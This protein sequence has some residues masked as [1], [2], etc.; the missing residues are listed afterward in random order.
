MNDTW[1][2][3]LLTPP[4]MS[5]IA[6]IGI[7]GEMGLGKLLARIKLRRDTSLQQL[8]IG[9][10]A[11][12]DFRHKEGDAAEEVV[13]V[14]TAADAME[15][16]CHGGRAAA[17]SIL[18]AIGLL[19]GDII[20]AERW[21]NQTESCPIRTDALMALSQVNTFQATRILLDQARGALR[22]E[23]EQTLAELSEQDALSAHAR[24][25]ELID[26]S[27][28][29]VRIITG[30]Q[31]ALLGRPNVGKS[32][33]LNALLGFGRAIV[34]DEPGTTRDVLA[35]QAAFDGWG[36]TLH[37]LAG[38]RDSSDP[39]EAEG[40]RRARENAARADLVLLVADAS[41]PWT[42]QDSDL[43]S[44]FREA[45]LVHNKSDLPADP[46]TRRPPGLSL[47]ARSGLG[48]PELQSAMLERLVRPQ[49][50][51]G[52]AV[53]FTATQTQSLTRASAY[54]RSN[55]FEPAR[56]ELLRLLSPTAYAKAT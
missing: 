16:Q 23:I 2:A 39:I 36:V 56:Q 47:S 3:A 13:V 31:V 28:I 48:L 55:Q 11:V 50:A 18:H 26:R 42:D 52:A 24:L 54:A 6:V 40:V 8:E 46:S 25:V 32:S 10:V 34:L 38:V 14:K 9:A 43:F 5:A 49:A 33:L 51:F 1:V 19:G 12:A 30:F 44:E 29:G 27:R 17:E 15:I 35:A 22:H 41:Q 21:A 4:G 37:D 53:P 45:L 7:R 20:P